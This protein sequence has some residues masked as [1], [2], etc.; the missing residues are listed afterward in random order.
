MDDSKNRAGPK[1]RPYADILVP[2]F[3]D[4]KY[5]LD[6]QVLYQCACAMLRT[7]GMRDT[8][9]DSYT[10]SIAFLDD[11]TA[12]MQLPLAEN[13]PHPDST[14]TRLALTA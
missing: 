12:L 9:W 6:I 3:W 5:D 13:F 7:N 8:G 2:L 11:F 10:E 4:H 1:V 14:Q